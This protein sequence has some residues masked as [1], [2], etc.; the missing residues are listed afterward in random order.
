MPDPY[1]IIFYLQGYGYFALYF[2]SIIEGPIVT[3]LAAFLS[4]FEYL[5]V[6]IVFA[7]AMLGDI[8]G[9]L[10][11]YSAGRFG[12]EK[13][14]IKLIKFFKISEKKLF[15]L[16]K[17]Y[18]NHG[19]KSIFLGKIVQGVAIP[20]LIGAGITKMKFSKFIS[21]SL[22]SSIIKTTFL[23]I[24]G[25]YF[26]EFYTLIE[27]WLGITGSIIFIIIIAIIIGIWIYKKHK[28]IKKIKIKNN[29]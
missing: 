17:F 1:T 22:A 8:T 12:K 25:Y 3:I 24:L 26:G 28:K 11:Y 27:K 29:R 10:I 19:G 20:I 13:F 6:F 4:S 16:E 9:D 21:Y 2:F 14:I 23:V 15:N 18:K 7:I 5:N